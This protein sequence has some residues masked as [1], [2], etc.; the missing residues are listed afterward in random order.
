MLSNRVHDDVHMLRNCLHCL[1]VYE[2]CMHM[3]KTPCF[4][5]HMPIPGNTSLSGKMTLY[6]RI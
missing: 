3:S 2:L 1:H 5:G 6:N 4:G